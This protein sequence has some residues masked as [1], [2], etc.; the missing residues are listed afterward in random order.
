[1]TGAHMFQR[2]SNITHMVVT[3]YQNILPDFISSKQWV[4]VNVKH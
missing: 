2:P 4:E 1:M 3:S